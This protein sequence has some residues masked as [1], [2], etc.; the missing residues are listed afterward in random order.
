[1]L[2]ESLQRIAD[3]IANDTHSLFILT[4]SEPERTAST[5][6]EKMLAL[7]DKPQKI[8]LK[9]IVLR[10]EFRLQ[11]SVYTP[12]Q[13]F[14]QIL[15]ADI[16]IHNALTLVLNEPF[17]Q[18]H[19]QTPK[20]DLYC[21]S[22][23]KEKMLSI[24]QTAPSKKQWEQLQHDDQKNYIISP[25][26]SPELLHALGIIGENGTIIPTMQAKFKQIN[27]FLSI[28]ATLDILKNPPDILRVID[29]G[30]GKAYLSFA[31]YHW[32]T[33]LRGITV[34]MQGVDS[35]QHVISFCQ[36]T[37]KKLNFTNATFTCGLIRSLEKKGS[38]D[39]LIALHACDTAT[40]DAL[41]LGIVREAKAILSA[42]CCH[43]YL[44][45][46]LKPANAPESVR[47][48]LSDGITRERFADL[49]TDSMRR[50][51]L[52]SKGYSAH[53]IEFISPEHTL[54][55]IM[56]K[57]EKSHSIPV[58]EYEQKVHEEISLWH[59]APKLAELVL[60]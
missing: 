58:K 50:D 41:A 39:L 25:Q 37:A 21:R 34:E 45:E 35:N 24:R 11:L 16:T 1:M 10:S 36:R 9:T 17:R 7:P 30:C 33:T 53:L 43:Y 40:D 31:L 12:K 23:G 26:N 48:L 52:S 4:M 49:L 57:A 27:H 8:T 20:A 51:I 5:Q 38:I 54:K 60:E 32:L 13:H 46:R 42:P 28:A 19:L 14:T 18:S 55:N 47:L 44:H 29:C 3:L 15:P 22:A 59:V 56:I 6:V 2:L